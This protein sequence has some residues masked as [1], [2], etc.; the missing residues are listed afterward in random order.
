MPFPPK[1]HKDSDVQS[2]GHGNRWQNADGVPG[3]YNAGG[4][5]TD[6][7]WNDA[8]TAVIRESGRNLSGAA[9]PHFGNFTGAQ[10]SL[11][12]QRNGYPVNDDVHTGGPAKQSVRAVDRH[13]PNHTPNGPAATVDPD[14][15]TAI[16][17]G[18]ATG[19]PGGRGTYAGTH[20]NHISP[21]GGGHV[22]GYL[23][24][25]PP[26]KGKEKDESGQDTRTTSTS[27]KPGLSDRVTGGAE[28]VFGKLM[29]NPGMVERGE[30]KKSGPQGSTQPDSFFST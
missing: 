6:A 15:R 18:T 3:A 21:T 10:E 24:A 14:S 1:D 5:Q 27:Q 25:V 28:K 23:G 29:K 7:N 17:P 30:I 20:M 9:G 16:P 8:S 26:R 13:Y 2:T 19:A 11:P 4:A 22:G 12:G